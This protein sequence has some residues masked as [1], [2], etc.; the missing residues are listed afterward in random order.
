VEEGH[1]AE[2]ERVVHDLDALAGEGVVVVRSDGHVARPE[3]G[4]RSVGR[5]V[6]SADELGL[7]GARADGTVGHVEVALG[8]ALELVHSLP[9]ELGRVGGA[10]A[11]QLNDGPGAVV[12]GVVFTKHDARQQAEAYGPRETVHGTH[13]RMSADGEK[14]RR[15][16][17]ASEHLP[18]L[19]RPAQAR[20]VAGCAAPDWA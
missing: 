12:P 20:A 17:C 18:E 4:V 3:V 8:F 9:Q 11:V 13:W 10:G 2:H 15:R 1:G 14:R 6:V 7:P 16:E 19:G 5:G